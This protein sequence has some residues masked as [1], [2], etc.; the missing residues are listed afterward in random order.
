MTG[1][2]SVKKQRK[3]INQLSASDIETLIV[4]QKEKIRN[5]KADKGN[6]IQ[7]ILE[8]TKLAR[9]ER[10]LENRDAGQIRL[11]C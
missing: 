5:S 11:Q 7:L 6:N 1:E 3:T 4:K 10:E 8:K 9:L 2:N